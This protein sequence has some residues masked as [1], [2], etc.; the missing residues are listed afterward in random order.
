MFSLSQISWG[1]G[2]LIASFESFRYTVYIS[3]R[4][5]IMKTAARA[6]GGSLKVTVI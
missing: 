5:S 1:E 2:T 3:L 6:A 4:P